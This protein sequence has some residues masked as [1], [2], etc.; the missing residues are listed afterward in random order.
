MYKMNAL[1]KLGIFNLFSGVPASL[2]SSFLG[3]MLV[4]V[5][6][7]SLRGILLLISLLPMLL[8]PISCLYGII[9][10]IRQR[11]ENRHGITCIILSFLG[12]ILFPTGVFLLSYF[13]VSV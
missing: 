6:S 10:G 1:L 12:M 9:C 11:K 5:F 8:S 4:S 13:G 7:G 2:A 3:L